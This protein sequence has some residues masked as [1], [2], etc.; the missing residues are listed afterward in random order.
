MTHYSEQQTRTRLIDMA[1]RKAGWNLGD[2]A[3]MG[4]EVPVDGTH[5]AEC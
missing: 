4:F 2:A 5:L 3:Q 1:L